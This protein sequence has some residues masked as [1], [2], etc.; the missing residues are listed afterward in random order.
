MILK[1]IFVQRKESYTG[2]Y[3]PEAMECMTE[4]AYD[5]YPEYLHEKLDGYKKDTEFVA[6]EIINIKVDVKEIEKR[7]YPDSSEI[8]GIIKE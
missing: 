1:V 5:E 8:N 6:A 3:A 7:L 4:Y 2:E